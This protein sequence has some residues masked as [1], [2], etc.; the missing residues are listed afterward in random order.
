MNHFDVFRDKSKGLVLEMGRSLGHYR[1]RKAE[2]GA[3]ID[4][5]HGGVVTIGLD[6]TQIC[7]SNPSDRP[8]A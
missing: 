8:V 2:S 3:Q 6:I 5:R 7:T 4:D 1:I